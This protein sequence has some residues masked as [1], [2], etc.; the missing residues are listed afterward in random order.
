MDSSDSAPGCDEQRDN[1]V[2]T[3]RTGDMTSMAAQFKLWLYHN[4]V[5]V[6]STDPRVAGFTK[7]FN[8]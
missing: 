7:Q 3:Y 8:H 5:C 2:R 4:S 6:S 1:M